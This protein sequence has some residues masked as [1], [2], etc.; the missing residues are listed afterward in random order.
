MLS[1]ATSYLFSNKVRLLL[2]VLS[3]AIAVFSIVSLVSISE[4]MREQITSQLEQF[5]PRSMVVIP[6]AQSRI[7]F[8]PG[9][10]RPTTGV[11]TD[12]DYYALKSLPFIST[13][14]RSISRYVFVEFK[15]E[16]AKIN[17]F[18]VEPVAF[19]DVVFVDVEKGRFLKEGE[20]GAAVIGAKIADLFDESLD[21][22]SKIKIE[23]RV[24]RVVGVLEEK[25][26][27]FFPIDNVI[28]IPYDDGKEVF[29]TKEIS[30][31]RLTVSE[32]KNIQE[33][34]K[35][36]KEALRLKRGVKEGEEDFSILSSRFVEQ[37]FT[38][39]LDLVSALF[40]GTAFVSFVVGA[41]GI[42][43]TVLMS[44]FERVREIGVLRAV[45]AK[46][47]FILTLFLMESVLLGAMGGVIGSGGAALLSLFLEVYKFRV[48]YALAGIIL[49]AFVGGLAGYLPAKKAADLDIAEA[50]RYE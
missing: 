7:T 12:K 9:A 30:A 36:I 38:A 17:V 37:R 13:I 25:G 3:I 20:R 31:I 11:L 29:D 15:E 40:I 27:S 5:G 49:A 4:G 35:E 26:N 45:G 39:V 19:Q 43:N 42:A 22:N 6:T 44:F 1:L 23:G 8:T 21:I 48:E 33:A 16:R 28:I 46:R 24:F 47:R 14:A 34:E 18:A 50:L 32:G 2:T 10:F 41:V